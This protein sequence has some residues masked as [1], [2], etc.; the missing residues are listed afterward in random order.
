MMATRSVGWCLSLAWLVACQTPRE[1]AA[2]A[3]TQGY[4]ELG[5]G[6]YQAAI[7]HF[8]EAINSEKNESAFE[9]RAEALVKLEND[10]SPAG[11][12][13]EKAAV[14]LRECEA[15]AEQKE[16]LAKAALVHFPKPPFS[17]AATLE[18]FLRL[19]EL[20]E[21]SASC[22]LVTAVGKA[23]GLDDQK[24]KLLEPALR[25]E[26]ARLSRALGAQKGDSP[27]Q[28]AAAG[29]ARADVDA[30]SC[31]ELGRRQSERNHGPS[32]VVPAGETVGP[33]HFDDDADG[34]AYYFAL[35]SAKLAMVR[36]SPKEEERLAHLPLA[37]PLDLA[38]YL[39]GMTKS[40][41]ERDCAVFMAILRSEGL[42]PQQR[43]V[44]K[45]PLREAV[46]S[47]TPPAG[48]PAQ[49]NSGHVEEAL[50][51]VFRADKTVSAA[52]SCQ[53]LDGHFATI[54]A[55]VDKLNDVLADG[56]DDGVVFTLTRQVFIHE[57][58]RLRLEPP[59]SSK[60]SRPRAKAPR[61]ER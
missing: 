28:R 21:G 39:E 31:E 52:R 47:L 46:D 58:L 11:V 4:I 45:K 41:Y 57:A 34:D 40:G 22:G 13:E 19:S 54:A 9:G 25:S 27:A 61:A 56:R 53:E 43:A 55:G 20:A 18:R 48:V 44:L 32:F 23:D 51:D 2:A 59:R 37:S 49:A 36:R 6:E 42:P 35:L 60:D 17:D 15:C 12:G 1:R 29:I 26:I 38:A 50:D 3:V 5:A 24:R 7:R 16:K 8:E 30:E 10:R 33:P 14:S